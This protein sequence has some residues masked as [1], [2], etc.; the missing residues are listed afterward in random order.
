ML[1]HGV[2]ADPLASAGIVRSLWQAT[3]LIITSY[4]ADE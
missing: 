4:I 1:I 2:A 3:R